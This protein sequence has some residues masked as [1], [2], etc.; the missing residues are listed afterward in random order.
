M[1]FEERIDRFCAH[2]PQAPRD[3]ILGS[4]LLLRTARLLRQHAQRALAPLALDLEQYLVLSM[5]ATDREKLSMP[6]ELGTVLDATRTQM[7]R[8]L[9]GLESRDLVRRHASAHDRRSLELELTAAGQR[10]LKRAAP[11]V[12]EAYT[13]AWTALE[14]AAFASTS[15]SLA[16]VHARLQELQP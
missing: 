3:F 11:L 13:Q 7:T 4:R 6:S 5:L 8:L 14:P 12:H 1:T 10:L 16:Q 15:R 2:H 9:D